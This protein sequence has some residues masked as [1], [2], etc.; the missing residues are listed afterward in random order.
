MSNSVRKIET[1]LIGRDEIFKALALAQLTGLPILL[2]GPPGTGKTQAI[3]EF[4]K[5]CMG[6]DSISGKE[7][8]ILETDEQTRSAEVKGR[9]DMEQLAIHDKFVI[10]APISEANYVLVNEIDKASSTIRNALLGIMN[11]KFVFNGKQKIEC[12]WDL[13][14][15]ACNIVPENEIGSPFWDR[16]IFKIKLER[17][18]ME[19]IMK[20]YRQGGKAFRHVVEIPWPSIDQLRNVV[21]PETKL[22]KF[23]KEM[24]TKCSDRTLTFLPRIISAVKFIY[25]CTITEAMLVTAGLVVGQDFSKKIA[26]RIT[27]PVA[28]SLFK[29]IKIAEGTKDK[30][31]FLAEC[32]KFAKLIDKTTLEEGESDEIKM[33]FEQM[34]ASSVV[35][36][37]L[38]ITN[39]MVKDLYTNKTWSRDLLETVK[40]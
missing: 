11:E 5:A 37:E 21:I 30:D 39:D 7:F 25:D 10:D 1:E 9:P 3:I 29:Q 24:H 38:Q 20:Y 32:E 22:A 35:G 4:G 31:R 33:V 27:S 15:G 14:A 17:M 19:N 34:V 12:N 18:S 16:F 28:N 2:E 23:L 40:S 13:F 6:T 8:F 26:G 36:Q